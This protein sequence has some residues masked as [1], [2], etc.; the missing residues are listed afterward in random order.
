VGKSTRDCELIIRGR[1]ISETDIIFVRRLAL[2]QGHTGRTNLSILLAGAWNWRQAN[3]RLKDRACRSILQELE[4]RGLI[5]LPVSKKPSGRPREYFSTS[6]SSI[7]IDTSPIQGRISEF[8]PLRIEPATD[9]Q[10][11][12][13]WNQVN[14]R[15]HYL[16]YRVLV[17]QNLKYLVYSSD[18]LIAALGWQSAMGSLLCRDYVIGW[19]PLQRQKHLSQIANNSR[20][21]M[22]PWV[23]IEHGASYI[24]SQNIKRLSNDWKDKYG[25]GLGALETFVDPARFRGTCYKAANW[26][27]VGQTRG[28]SKER[29]GFIYHGAQK[30]VYLYVL[31]KKLR[32][33]IKQDASEALLTRKF[34]LSINPSIRRRPMIVR[35]ENWNPE[36][37]P[38]VNLNPA[39][40]NKLADELESF[41]SLFEDAFRR[42]EQKD[43]SL[44][45]FQGLLTT[46]DRKSMEPIALQLR[47]PDKVRN[48]QRFMGE[49]KW[50]EEL[51]AARH[52][53]EVSKT[54]AMPDGVLSVDSSETPKKGKESVG[55]SRQY[56]GRIGKVENCQ[57]GVFVAY[58]SSK[59]YALID[60]KLFMPEN[61]FSKE[62]EERREKCKVP[63]DIVFKKK[64]ELAAEMVK[65][66]RSSGL[67]TGQWITCD[68]IFGNSPDFIGSL[69]DGL[70]YL[71]DVPCDKTVWRENAA[72]GKTTSQSVSQIANDKSLSWKRVKLDEGAKGPIVC[73]IARLRV[74]LDK[75]C[76]SKDERWLFLRKCLENGEIK[77]CLSNAPKDISLNEMVR[78][79]ILRWPIEQSFQEGKSDLGMADYEHRSWPAWHR[80]MTF[81]FLAQLFLIRVRYKLKKNARFDLTT[82]AN[83]N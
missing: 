82:S 81:V 36:I 30:E 29:D 15:H 72:N 1:K 44:C 3:G 52:K 48:L 24:L 38:E 57:S 78:V 20:F 45:Y 74:F 4:F 70:Y 12:R 73:S 39:D 51:M 46:L 14:Q 31:D 42:V 76:G 61:W 2:E 37:E 34:L 5:K 58:T 28:F 26:V 56:C 60:R 27:R 18:R 22:L 63:K 64:T 41:H 6:E 67:F 21:L 33:K 16:G 53:E 43:L 19:N 25:H 69:P 11:V 13:L 9:R 23:S 66:L 47:G 32:R 71:A 75:S 10:S 77:Y 55:V 35:P 40:I 68:A 50:D 80:H 59:G 7:A 65:D 83:A 62:Q 79:C 54:L 17:G 8:L 49:Y